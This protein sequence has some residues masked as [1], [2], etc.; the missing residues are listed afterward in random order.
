MVSGIGNISESDPGGFQPA[1]IGH[2]RAGL[3][4]GLECFGQGGEGGAED[5]G[6]K[7]PL[8][9]VAPAGDD[10]AADEKRLKTGKGQGAC[11]S[12]PPNALAAED[13]DFHP[14]R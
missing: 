13:E 8:G 5:S 9:R 4:Q 3:V 1:V 10:C 12:L 6:V 14:L 7:S 2:D 11:A